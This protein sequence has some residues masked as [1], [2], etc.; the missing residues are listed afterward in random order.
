MSSAPTPGWYPDPEITGHIRYWDGGAWVPDSSR[1][2]EE[3]DRPAAEQAEH[4]A[5]AEQSDPS[6]PSAQAIGRGGRVI[7]GEVLSARTGDV[8]DMS[9]TGMYARP[10]VPPDTEPAPGPTSSHGPAPFPDHVAASAAGP[11]GAPTADAVPGPR[12]G[13]GPAPWRPVQADIFGSNERRP[14]GLGRRLLARVADVLVPL[15][16]GTAVGIPLVPDAIDHIRD[17]IDRA[18]YEGRDTTVWLLDGTTGTALA[19]VLGTVIVAALLYEALPTWRWG[20]SL[21]KTLFGLRVADL[22]SHDTPTLWQSL[23]R[24]L[25]LYV[26]GVAVVGV[27]G[28]L[29]ALFDR[30]WRQGLHDK[31]ARTFV[32]RD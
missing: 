14:A 6:A 9:S 16:A 8:Y 2:A 25:V 5:H 23:R 10:P 12:P 13:D 31:A 3:P 11:F 20:R 21:G 7:Q 17:K 32:A 27:L 26:A 28:A 24:W 4:A 30:P 19:V 1:P 22:D 15:A 29:W 18:R